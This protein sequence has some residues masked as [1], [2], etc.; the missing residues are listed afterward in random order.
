M[1]KH[2]P[3]YT[4]LT[5][6]FYNTSTPKRKED[7]PFFSKKSFHFFAPFFLVKAK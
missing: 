2:L 5:S 3:F 6:T 1:Q 7:V 4:S